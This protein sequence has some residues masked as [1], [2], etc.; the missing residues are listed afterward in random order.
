MMQALKFG[1]KDLIKEEVAEINRLKAQSPHF[2]NEP[3]V[4]DPSDAM[5]YVIN[6]FLEWYNHIRQP[7]LTTPDIQAIAIETYHL[8]WLLKR[9]FPATRGWAVCIIIMMA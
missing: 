6:E 9:V 1:L 2:K 4:E 7:L 3:D 5:I 8:Q